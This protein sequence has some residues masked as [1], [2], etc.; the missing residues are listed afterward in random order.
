MPVVV[1]VVCRGR[2]RQPAFQHG[3]A[4]RDRKVL[5]S[6][7]TR[8][9][10]QFPVGAR[11]EPDQREVAGFTVGEARAGAGQRHRH[12]VRPAG[13]R[14]QGL[15]FELPGFIGAVDLHGVLLTYQVRQFSG[16]N[17]LRRQTRRQARGGD[18]G[19]QATQLARNFHRASRVLSAARMRSTSRTVL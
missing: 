4:A 6:K 17:A 16:V 8:Q 2:H 12:I 11:P 19:Q 14:R 15:P 13:W 5:V 7:E 10:Q 9:I 3:E 1:L 18:A